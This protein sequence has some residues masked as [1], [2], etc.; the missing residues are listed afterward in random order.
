MESINDSITKPLY[1]KIDRGM[2][3]VINNPFTGDIY[4]CGEDKFLKKY[5]FPSETY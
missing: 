4:V 1:K 2:N 5:D 3:I